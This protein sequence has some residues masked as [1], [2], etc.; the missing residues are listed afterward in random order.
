MASKFYT[1]VAKGLKLKIRKFLGLI[2]TFLEITGKQLVNRVNNF[3]FKNSNED[4]IL[5]ITLT[6]S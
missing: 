2:P 1:C 4:K 5:G 6:T 3:I